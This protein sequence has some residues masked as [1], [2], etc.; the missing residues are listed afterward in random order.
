[1]NTDVNAGPAGLVRIEMPGFCTFCR[2]R[3][4]SLN[5]IENGRLVAVKP[6]PSLSGIVI[7]A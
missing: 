5:V 1:M 6:L 2:W 7:G 3:C 4:G